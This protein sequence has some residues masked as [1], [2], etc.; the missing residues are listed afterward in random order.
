MLAQK[1]NIRVLIVALEHGSN[2]YDLK[3][4]GGGV[5]VQTPDNHRLVRNDL[6]VVTQKKPTEQQMDDLLS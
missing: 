1:N 6:K 2:A 5:L 3:R 4:I